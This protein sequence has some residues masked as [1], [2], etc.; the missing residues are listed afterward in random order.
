MQRQRSHVAADPLGTLIRWAYCQ[1]MRGLILS[2][3]VPMIFVTLPADNFPL[4]GS[5][6]ENEPCKADTP[7][8]A[9]VT[10]R[11]TE[12]NSAMG[13]C[14]ILNFR[15]ERDTF[16]VDVE[17]N[18]PA[19]NQLIANVRFTPRTEQTIDFA[20]EDQSYRSVLYRCP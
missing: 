2:Y 9:R 6:M 17:C 16:A 3:V 11:A 20:D 15:H 12:I 18:G 4:I 1:R 10:I 14:K 19:G 8:D 5:Y 13:H 7:T